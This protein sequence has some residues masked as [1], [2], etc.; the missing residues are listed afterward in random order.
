MKDRRFS[1]WRALF[2]VIALVLL[3]PSLV[4]AKVV[5]Y[6][7]LGWVG[8]WLVLIYGYLFLHPR[9]GRPPE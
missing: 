6:S 1:W 4:V 2:V 8:L 3:R 7:P 5:L 9:K